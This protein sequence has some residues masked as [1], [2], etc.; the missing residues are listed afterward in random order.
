MW[1]TQ[2][3]SV[4][5]SSLTFFALT[6]WLT[7]SLYPLPEQKADLAFALSALGLTFGVPALLF[8]PLAGSWADHH[9][10]K[11]T[12]LVTDVLSGLLSLVLVALVV[13]G[14]LQLSTLMVINVLFAVLG[15]FHGAAFDTSYAMLVPEAQ[16]PRANGMMQSVWSLAGIV[17]PALAASL[18]AL[19]GLARQGALPWAGDLLAQLNDGAALAM[20]FDAASFFVAGGVL[21]FL[22]VPTPQAIQ[23][24]RA[25]GRRASLRED[26]RLG[27]HYIWQ[28]R[29][30]LWLLG[31]FTM[32]N[33]LTAFNVLTPLL[34]KFNLAP[35]WQAR[36]LSFEAAL[37]LLNSIGSAGGVAGGLLVSTWG[38]LKRRRV[39]G[40][41][42]PILL[43]AAAQVVLGL[44]AALY[45]VAVMVLVRAAMVPIMNS[46]S[47]SIW[48]T[49]TPRELQ[50]R[51]FSVRRVIAQFTF[52]LGTALA[53]WAG[54][55]FDVGLLIAGTGLMLAVFTAAQ[56]FNPALLRVDDKAWLDGL[57]TREGVGQNEQ[58]E[59]QSVIAAK[60]A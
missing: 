37:A 31:T 53:G 40:V 47:Q 12:M 42:I 17:A 43:T 25:S 18:I 35:D 7:Q 39:L 52:P 46:H 3:L 5:G 2:S 27:I 4:L 32:V 30:L 38:G 33:L 50:G 26:V 44:S 11:R 34:L 29:P 51:V 59:H 24:E 10:R 55:V 13:S 15:T 54:G 6:I 48:Q 20:A 58:N 36:G 22:N 23:A 45:V 21:I 60:S 16:L 9:D 14:A 8:G 49:Q 1:A 41:L 57:A 28:R 56:F 19:P